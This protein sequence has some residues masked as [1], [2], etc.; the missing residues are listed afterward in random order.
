MRLN[1][2]ASWYDAIDKYD[3]GVTVGAGLP[4]I[5]LP[6]PT[7]DQLEYLAMILAASNYD[8]RTI[9]GKK[10]G[11]CSEGRDCNCGGD[12]AEVRMSC[13]NWIKAE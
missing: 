11:H 5:T 8:P 7:K 3:E 13:P 4:T 9:I 12:T 1:I 10:R 2:P 6:Q